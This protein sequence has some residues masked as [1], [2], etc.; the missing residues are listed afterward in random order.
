MIDK[1]GIGGEIMKR[2]H[3]IIILVILVIYLMK[4]GLIAG[5]TEGW[6]K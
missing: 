6:G 2:K 5:F 4:D 1:E 3:I